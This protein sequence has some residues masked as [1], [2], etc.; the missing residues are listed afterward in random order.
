[1]AFPHNPPDNTIFTNADTKYKWNATKRLW[2]KVPKESGI[3]V[4]TTGTSVAVQKVWTGNR[5]EFEV[6][7][8]VSSIIYFVKD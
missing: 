7:T 4:D 2:T 6:I 8:P 1:M 3:T 5:A